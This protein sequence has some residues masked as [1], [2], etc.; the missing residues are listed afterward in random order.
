MT[1]EIEHYFDSLSPLL[2]LKTL[3]AVVIAAPDKFPAQAIAEAACAVKSILCEK[4][5][6]LNLAQ[7]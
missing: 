7:R 3:E 4:P 5:V 1:L 2:Q 6:A